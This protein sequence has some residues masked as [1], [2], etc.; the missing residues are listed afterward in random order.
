MNSLALP[1]LTRRIIEAAAID[2]YPKEAIGVILGTSNIGV[3]A[4]PIAT[5]S[6]RS[7]WGVEVLDDTELRLAEHL[8]IDNIIGEF[9]SH[10]GATAAASPADKHEMLHNNTPYLGDGS[11]MCVLGIWP[12]KAK[13]WR[14]QWAVYQVTG[15][16]I[17]RVRLL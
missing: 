5:T 12:G 15:E 3:A 1:P 9:H 7:A 4:F 14:F 2:A 6:K 11:Y 16:K 17:R 8:G 10:P 13:P